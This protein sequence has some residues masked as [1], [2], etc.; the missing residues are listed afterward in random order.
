MAME[1]LIFATH[2]ANKVMEIRSLLPECFRVISLEEVGFR[3]EIPEPH[4]TLEA[5]AREKSVTIYHALGK[6]CF[7]EDSGLE[8]DALKG[9]PGVFSA[10]YA[11]PEKSAR[12]NIDR[13]LKEMDAETD[14]TARFR[15]VISLILQ[16][17]EVQFE[18]I[19]AGRITRSPQGGEGFGYD[20]VF[21][22]DGAE[23]TFARMTMEEKN[24]F[25]HRAKALQ[26]LIDF[27]ISHKT[28]G[29]CQG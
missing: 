1:E 16:G 22:P 8:V 24:A 29:S 19:C 3:D 25:S 12:D 23:K 28:F 17:E 21:I 15:T 5:N 9:A 6:N 4:A 7:S 2:N 26:K 14:R 13:L 20:P 27:L 10:R 18:G 11:G